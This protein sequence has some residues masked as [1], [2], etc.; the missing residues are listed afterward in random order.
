[1]KI[2]VTHEKFPPEIA[3]GGETIVYNLVKGLIKKGHRVTVLT[4]GN[5]KIK[6][7]DGIKT[8]RIPVNRYL[9]N[10]SYPI[11][12]KYA[13]DFD[14]IQTTSGN[15]CF[16]SWKVAKTLNK[17]ICCLILHMLAEN[18]KTIR[19]HLIGTV[20][21]ELEKLFLGRSY[22]A[23]VAMNDN[24]K[25]L[26]KKIN[27]S[28][29]IYKIPSGFNIPQVKYLE[30]T[31]SILFVGNV[32]MNESMS[33]LKGLP[34]FLQ[35]AKYFGDYKFYVVGKGDYLE[36]IRKD[37]PSNV[38]FTGPL[39]GRKLHDLF[40]K[41]LIYCNLSLSEGFGLT[42]AEAMASGCAVISTIDIGQAGVLSK[43]KDVQSLVK[44]IRHFINNPS[45]VRRISKMNKKLAKNYTWDKFVN[46]FIQVYKK[47]I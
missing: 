45:E 44:F 25:S 8:I 23:I 14:L 20:F 38:I 7:Y 3:G 36:T 37:A 31:K 35:A 24:A 6:E 40:N 21:H 10:L 19:G 12:L 9:M 32:S 33:N 29:K 46:G 18:W 26:I 11:I 42:T 30:K 15:M 2:L 27:K 43:P 16:A 41:S 13:K 22:N 5:P 1:M 47:I 4:T 17:P 39:F 34:E 28:S